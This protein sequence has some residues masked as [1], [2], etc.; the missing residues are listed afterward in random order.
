MAKRLSDEELSKALEALRDW[1]PTNGR[2]GISR[3][4][5]FADFAEAWGFMSRVALLAE[6]HNHHPEWTNVY[7][8][9]DIVLT[10]HD[11]GGMSELDVAMAQAIDSLVH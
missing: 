3:E 2:E 9:V 7:G 5:R 8:R 4:F 1:I 10:T 6:K 11:V